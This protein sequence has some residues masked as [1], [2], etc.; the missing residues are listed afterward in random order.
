MF[1]CPG[2]HRKSGCKV[3]HLSASLGPCE[4]CG[5]TAKTYDCASYKKEAEDDKKAKARERQR[6]ARRL[7]RRL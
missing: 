1:L 7:I 5:Q 6:E 2:C 4:N 3:Q